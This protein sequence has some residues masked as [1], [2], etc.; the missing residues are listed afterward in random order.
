MTILTD[1]MDLAGDIIQALMEDFNIEVRAKAEKEF[2]MINS[3]PFLF[4]RTCLP[5]Q[6][7][8]DTWRISKKY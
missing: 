7:F 2:E 5:W 3:W 8:P 4:C 6:N 1:D